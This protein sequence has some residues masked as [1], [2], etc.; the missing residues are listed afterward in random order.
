MDKKEMALENIPSRRYG[1]EFMPASQIGT[2]LPPS[3]SA[4]PP[5]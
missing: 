3:F 1:A 2:F 4:I 5:Y